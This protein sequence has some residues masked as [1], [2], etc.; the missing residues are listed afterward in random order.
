MSWRRRT[1]GDKTDKAK[2]QRE[3]DELAYR[4]LVGEYEGPE[5]WTESVAWFELTKAKRGEP[6]LGT[7]TFSNCRKRL[8]AKRKVRIWE[9]AKNK[10]YQAV[11]DAG[12]PLTDEPL[13]PEPPIAPEGPNAPEGPITPT[14]STPSTPSTPTLRLYRRRVEELRSDPESAPRSSGVVSSKSGNGH[15]QESPVAPVP[16][17]AAQALE[18]LLN[19]KPPAGV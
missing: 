11:F 17:K 6:G 10:F 16:D 3:L 5:S 7:T 1:V 4:V 15:S 18:R 8:L 13:G 19:K 9:T 2:R 14:P 12:E